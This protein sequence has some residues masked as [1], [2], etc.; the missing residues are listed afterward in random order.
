MTSR[1]V[2]RP[3]IRE[4]LWHSFSVLLKSYSAAA[5]MSG[6][7]Q[8]VLEL[9]PHSLNIVATSTTLAVGYFPAVGKGTWSVRGRG[10]EEHG[11]FEFNHDGTVVLDEAEIDMD[12]AA[13]QLLGSLTRAARLDEIE[14][15]A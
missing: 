15:P 11:A 1:S 9:S 10:S 12:H 6:L 3:D 4:E 8:G 5:S 2:S 13:I 14:V 7:S